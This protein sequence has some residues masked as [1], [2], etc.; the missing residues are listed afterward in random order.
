[1][2]LYLLAISGVTC[3][4][5]LSPLAAI[6]KLRSRSFSNILIFSEKLSE[7][8]FFRIWSLLKCASKIP[9]LKLLPFWN[10]TVAYED[11]LQS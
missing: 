8:S 9:A 7:A 11:A 2:S 1:M 6:A 4:L 10:E 5:R 3:F